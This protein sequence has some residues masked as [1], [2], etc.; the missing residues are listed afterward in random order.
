MRTVAPILAAGEVAARGRRELKANGIYWMVVEDREPHAR[1][2]LEHQNDWG[3]TAIAYAG[4]YR[5]WFL[6]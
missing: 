1:D 2:L 5:L 3:V 4:G 6:N